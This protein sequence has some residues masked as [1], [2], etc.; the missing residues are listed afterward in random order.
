MAKVIGFSGSAV[1]SGTVEKA[2][3]DVLKSTGEDW[4][5]IRLNDLNMKQCIGC[6][7]C[8]STY[9][10]ILKD[11]INEIL[12]KVIQADAIVMGSPARIGGMTGLTKTFLERLFPL[13]HRDMPT[14]GKIAASVGGGLFH[15]KNVNN[16]LSQFYKNFGMIEAGSINVGGNASCYKC[17]YGETCDHSAFIALYGEGAKI[18]EDVFYS[19]DKDEEAKEKAELLGKQIAGA[20]NSK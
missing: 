7:K 2:L 5:L 4:E 8:A 19:F 13:Y 14:R 9:R 17:G 10:C 18:T 15:N 11:D 16:E 3:E 12:D 1:R 6:T 20:L